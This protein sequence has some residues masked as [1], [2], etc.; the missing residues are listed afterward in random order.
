MFMCEESV[1]DFL[2][3]WTPPVTPAD[4]PVGMN[5]HTITKALEFGP[6]I[7]AANLTMYPLLLGNDA[8]AGYATLD[9]A[10]AAGSV[11]V[12]EVSESGH[13]PELTIV[14]DGAVPVLVLDGEELVGAK[15][16]RIV[17]L[18]ILVP[19]HTRLP[20]PVS[21]VEAGRWAHRSHAFAAAGRAHYASGRAMKVQQVSC[22]LRTDGERHA[23]Q[24]A[25]WGDID[26]KAERM[27]AH[28][29][30]RAAAAMYEQARTDLDAFQSQLEAVP[31]QVG[32]VF[33][34]NGAIVGME[35]FDSAAT[36]RKS[37]RKIVES[38]GLDALDRR[39]EG[40]GRAR[41]DPKRFLASVSATA[42]ETFPAVGLG[43][44]LRLRSP[45]IAGAALAV[46]Q[47]LA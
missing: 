23:D 12:T 14:N 36:W 47:Q 31:R 13:V 30:T 3:R 9:E 5:L 41:R 4:Y 39:A 42:V 22:S 8:P 19:P 26:A 18:S 40:R 11:Q 20:L 44:D 38:Y 7:G 16:N 35:L 1:H 37:M 45:R 25:I 28:S 32:A 46:D 2:S 10:L 27:A 43:D 21:C 33:A 6:T 24:G 34:I 29:P 17:N 15:Q